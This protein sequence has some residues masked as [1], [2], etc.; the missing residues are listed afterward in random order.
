MKIMINID[1]YLFLMFF[2]LEIFYFR[3]WMI[4]SKF[5]IICETF[6]VVQMSVKVAVRV[7]PFNSRELKLNTQCVV[8]MTDPTTILK[9]I[10]GEEER[11]FTF[12]YSFWS[13]DG[14]QEQPNGFLKASGSKYADQ[15]QV[16]EKIGKNILDNAWQGYHCCLFAYGQTGS[17]KSYSMIGYG[18]NK[19]DIRIFR[20]LF[21]L[22]AIKFLRESKRRKQVKN[23]K[24]VLQCYKYTMSKFKI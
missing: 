1:F 7:R 10:N 3:N 15:T 2:Y 20:V 24:S 17:G 5:I 12:D 22:L 11:R 9:P 18:E 16:F 21:Q 14:Y 8:D 19:V 6:S 13:F 4:E 23:L